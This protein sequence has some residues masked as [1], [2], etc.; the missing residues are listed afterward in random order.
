ME[1]AKRFRIG[2]HRS[3]HP[4]ETLAGF[5][6]AISAS[7]ITRVAGLTGLD[8]L[9]VPVFAAI[10]PR[11]RYLVVSQGKGWT[12]AAA[13]ASAVGESLERWVAE[14]L[15]SSGCVAS[16]EQLSRTRPVVPLERLPQR[17]DVVVTAGDA[18]EW[19]KSID[20]LTGEPIWL[21]RDFV[22]LDR[23]RP[24]AFGNGLFPN[25]S[26]GLAVGNNMTEA[27]VHAICEI[28]ERDAV[29][30]WR[31]RTWAHSLLK[32]DIDTVDIPEIREV[33]R[34]AKANNIEVAV[35]D[36]TSD[37]GIPV[38]VCRMIDTETASFVPSKAI[39]GSGCHVARDVALSR[40]VAEAAQ[41]RLTMISGS[42]DDLFGRHY[43]DQRHDLI[44]LLEST[45]ADVG[46]RPFATVP[47]PVSD[48]LGD[49]LAF[50]LECC[51]K[52][53]IGNVLAVDLSR[54]E[55]GICAVRVVI[56][57]LEDGQDV[58]DFVP[59]ARALS[60]YWGAMIR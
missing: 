22:H 17:K 32:L 30:L 18:V 31:L 12:A 33:F 11:T 7:G 47:S 53:G 42:R 54:P 58:P 57:D 27:L 24:P 2:T 38:F 25:H 4:R 45:V 23:R 39:D 14:Y 50:L 36:A 55:L 19:H 13:K 28:I 37:L 59:R 35:W 46:R 44:A 48:D 56:P 6:K 1:S 20:L 40:A 5:V 15:P 29:T 43:A 41:G 52:S 9:G 3:K 60:A 49:D 34:R 10:R 26:T 51:R 21:P 16:Y 8:I